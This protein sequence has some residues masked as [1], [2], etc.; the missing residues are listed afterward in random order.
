MSLEGQNLKKYQIDI[1]KLRATF[2]YIIAPVSAKHIAKK[3]NGLLAGSLF[4][5]YKEITLRRLFAFKS[6]SIDI[7]T[8][9]S[10]TTL[11]VL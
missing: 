9:V 2:V 6:H 1:K 10:L 5:W 8:P 7:F 4:T 11:T 3:A